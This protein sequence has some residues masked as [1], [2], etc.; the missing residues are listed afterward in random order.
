V[1]GPH[2]VIV[3]NHLQDLDTN[4][5]SIT[6]GYNDWHVDDTATG[7][8]PVYN[9]LIGHNTMV[10]VSD[11]VVTRNAGFNSTP[12]R[13]VLPADVKMVNNIL[14]STHETLIQGTEGTGWTWAGNQAFGT[15]VG[16]TDPGINVVNPQMVT[17][18]AGIWRLSGSSP[19][20]NAGATGPWALPANDMDGQSRF[21]GNDIGADELSGAAATAGPL[22]GSDVGPAWLKRRTMS[23]GAIPVP[24]ILMEAEDFTAVRDPNGDGDAWNVFADGGASGGEGLRAPGGTRTDLPGTHDAVV[25]YDVAFHDPGTYYLYVLCRGLTSSTDSIY[26]PGALGGAPDTAENLPRGAGWAWLE[27]ATYTILAGDVNRPITLQLGKREAGAEIDM[28]LFSPTQLDFSAIPEP[29][30]MAWVMGAVGLLARRGS[31]RR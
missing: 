28:L 21:G 14:W 7:Y 9:V 30:C 12:N 23:V 24:V 16:K 11:Q 3:N 13:I 20:I 6:T 15:T 22:S 4:A 29:A 31:R 27:M 8:E 18:A 2:H 17:D 19:A 25:E 1:I 5:L 26:A 10:N